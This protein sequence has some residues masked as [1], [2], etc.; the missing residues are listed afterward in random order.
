MNL[1][2]WHIYILKEHVKIQLDILLHDKKE[3]CYICQW[4]IVIIV[5]IQDK[6]MRNLKQKNTQRYNQWID[7][8]A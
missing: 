3:I 1:K 4:S 8:L 2:L 5:L 6:I 7:F